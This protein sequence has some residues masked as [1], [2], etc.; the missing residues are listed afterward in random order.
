MS[1]P[2]S[3]YDRRREMERAKMLAGKLQIQAML[4]QRTCEKAGEQADA[5]VWWIISQAAVEAL[6]ALADA[7]RV[8]G[9]DKPPATVAPPPEIQRDHQGVPAVEEKT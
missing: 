3:N 9:A 2:S 7:R 1:R 8:P 6:N 5:M 4:N